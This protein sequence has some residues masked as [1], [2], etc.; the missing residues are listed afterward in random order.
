MKPSGQ[1]EYVALQTIVERQLQPVLETYKDRVKINGPEFLLNMVAAQQIALTVHELATNAIKYGALSGASGSIDISCARV[2]GKEPSL[3]FHW[4]EQG[5]TPVA[6][7]PKDKGGF[8]T[9][10]LTRAVPV[11]LGG[12]ATRDFTRTGLK[13]FLTVAVAKYR[14]RAAIGF[15]SNRALGKWKSC[16][17]NAGQ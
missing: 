1:N 10:L 14:H 8:G 15:A 7:E 3:E 6:P 4:L 11:L 13:Y 17:Q 2:E 16:W 9:Q 12:K 5:G